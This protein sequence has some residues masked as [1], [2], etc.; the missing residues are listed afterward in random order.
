MQGITKKW[1]NL[2]VVRTVSYHNPHLGGGM[3]HTLEAALVAF[4]F[5]LQDLRPRGT[6]FNSCVTG[7]EVSGE[8][9][10]MTPQ[11][12]NDNGTE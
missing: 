12:L 7:T 8:D 3:D 4:F 11:R 10:Q 6:Y 9:E 2:K 5:F 1:V